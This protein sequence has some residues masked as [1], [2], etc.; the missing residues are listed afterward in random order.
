MER[1]FSE[2][3]FFV[4]FFQAEYAP[5]RTFASRQFSIRRGTKALLP[6]KGVQGMN[7]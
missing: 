2:K 6:A 7:R 1:F 3:L 4:G 5:E